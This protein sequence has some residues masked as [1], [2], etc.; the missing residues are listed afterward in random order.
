[1]FKKNLHILASLL[2]LTI[3]SCAELKP[4][5]EEVL[6]T[7][8]QSLSPSNEETAGAL[9]EALLQGAKMASSNLG[10]TGGYLDNPLLKIGLPEEAGQMLQYIGKIPGGQQLVNQVVEGINRSAEEAAKEVVPI[11]AN[12]VKE[13]TFADALGIL[14]GGE[15]AATQYFKSKTKDQLYALYQ[16][17]IAASLNKKLLPS[18][19]TNEAW[20]KL[21]GE[22]NKYSN[23]LVGQVAG[24]KSINEN[25]DDYLTNKALEGLFLKMAEEENL[26]RKDPLKRTSDLMKKVFKFAK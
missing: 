7:W 25:V 9:K 5:G 4:L 10:A 22:W 21:T 3:A 1:M 20:N 13:L 14:Q 17:K 18:M 15:G 11:F 16:P 6:N 19:T 26:I 12:S 8:S 23:S 24:M 2:M